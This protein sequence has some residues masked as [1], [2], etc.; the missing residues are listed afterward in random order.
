MS[1]A[2]SQSHKT[3]NSLDAMD[4]AYVAVFAALLAALSM[5]PLVW[6]PIVPTTLQTLGV[7]LCGLCLGPWRGAAAAGLYVLMGAVGL[8]VLAEGASGIAILLGPTGGYLLSFPVA[9]LAT[10]FVAR[11]IVRRGLSP[12]TPLWLL[13]TLLAVR[14]LVIMPMGVLGLMRALEMDFRTAFAID[15]PFWLGDLVKSVIA[16]LLATA[17]HKAFP[18]L[19]GRR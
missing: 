7:A 15:V 8:P 9:A 2:A 19:L 14:Y 6:G 16:A 11:A 3:Q 17:V 18:R 5:V 12:L 1:T 13:L 10:G 4:L